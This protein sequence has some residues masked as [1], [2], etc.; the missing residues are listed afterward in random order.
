[1]TGGKIIIA[2]SCPPPGEGAKN[3]ID[4]N[5]GGFGNFRDTG[6]IGPFGGG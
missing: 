5:R 2:G 6:A 4:F 1:M 3:A